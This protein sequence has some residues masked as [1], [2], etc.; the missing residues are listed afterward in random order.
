MRIISWNVNGLR[1]CHRKGFGKWLDECD[2]EIVALQE[3]RA[4]REQL[5]EELVERDG[6]YFDVAAAERGGYSG[7]A[8]FSRHPPDQLQSELGE[9]ELDVE[10]RLQLARFGPLWLVNGYFPNGNGPN[11]DLSRIPYKLRFYRWLFD[12]L[13]PIKERGEPILVMGDLNT[14]HQDIDLARPKQNRK[15]SGFRPEEREELDRWL[16]EGWVDTFRHFV[17]EEGGHY[18]W[19]S[20]RL[21]AR[22]RNVGWRLDFV[23]ASPGAM[24]HLRGATIHAD[25]EGSD[26]CPVSVDVAPALLG[27]RRRTRKKRT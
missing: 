5:P 4:R 15:T 7:V 6:W 16:R 10:G 22:E 23:L 17:P 1:A 26:H 21:G 19:W 18:S 8:L 12:H 27:K 13:E 20:Q 25:V 3:V 24:P 9:E 11:R 14:A 2:A